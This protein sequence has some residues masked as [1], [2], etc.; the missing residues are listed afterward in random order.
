MGGGR[1][2]GVLYWIC[3]GVFVYKFV[4]GIIYCNVYDEALPGNDPTSKA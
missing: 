4:N 3:F 2:Y 1:G